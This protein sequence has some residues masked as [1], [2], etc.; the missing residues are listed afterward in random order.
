MDNIT[1]IDF[2]VLQQTNLLKQLA[3]KQSQLEAQ[4]LTVKGQILFSQRALDFFKGVN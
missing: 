2:K 4:L 1:S 3:Y